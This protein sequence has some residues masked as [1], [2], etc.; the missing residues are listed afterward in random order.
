MQASE[1]QNSKSLDF[2][3]NRLLVV[4]N[5]RVSTPL[6]H[7]PNSCNGGGSVRPKPEVRNS[8]G[9]PRECRDPSSRTVVCGCFPRHISRGCIGNSAAAASECQPQF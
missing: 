2:I 4:R 1:T 7:S 8:A 3:L 9:F 5:E 6:L